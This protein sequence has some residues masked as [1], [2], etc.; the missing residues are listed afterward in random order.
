M[1]A[2]ALHLTPSQNSTPKTV[3]PQPRGEALPSLAGSQGLRDRFYAWRGK[4]GRRYVCS[5]FRSGEEGFLAGVTDGAIV[6]VAHTDATAR[7]VCV[8][9]A[10]HTLA[11]KDL[12]AMGHELG[13]VEWHVH[14]SGETD[15][16][17]GDLSGSL[18]H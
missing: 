2:V 4:S 15:N 12:R 16:V 10:R 9:A 14:F 13:V 6:G 5:V 7:P 17:V 11:T 8:I 3:S 18:L 1:P